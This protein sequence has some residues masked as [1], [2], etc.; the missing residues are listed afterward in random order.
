[1]CF[2]IAKSST[3]SLSLS[4]PLP[5]L[6]P[7]FLLFSLSLLFSLC[8][9][10]ILN[11]SLQFC[12]ISGQH[13][14]KHSIVK[15]PDTWWDGWCRNFDTTKVGR[16]YIQGLSKSQRKFLSLYMD[17]I[18]SRPH[19]C[20]RLRY[21]NRK[22]SNVETPGT[23]IYNFPPEFIKI[24]RLSPFTLIVSPKQRDL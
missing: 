14:T 20:L 5:D 9:S 24:T 12:S 10:L 15:F 4:L 1:M 2:R 21:Y 22:N 6:R 11:R 23:N 8:L 3:Y 17:S 18:T 19:V 7:L 16:C 13:Q